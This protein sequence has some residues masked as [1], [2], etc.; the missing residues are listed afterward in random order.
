MSDPQA[1]YGY[2][3]WP[4]HPTS[5]WLLLAV[6]AAVGASAGCGGTKPP[7][8]EPGT[9]PAR[10]PRAAEQPKRETAKAQPVAV[11]AEQLTKEVMDGEDA[12][13][14][15]YKDR[16]LIVEGPFD[17]SYERAVAGSVARM[18]VLERYSAPGSSYAIIS[19]VPADQWGKVDGLTKGLGSNAAWCH[20]VLH[21]RLLAARA[22]RGTRIVVLDPRRTATADVADLHLPL[23]PGSDVILFN[24]RITTLDRQNPQA[25]AIAIRGDRFVAAGPCW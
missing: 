16:Q 20:P 18:M 13:N 23:A 10:G 24:G 7:T 5:T 17:H 9:E 4:F 19:K 22:A 11:T 15:K 25:Q 12:A 3:R 2:H 8:P 14:A 1:D 21:Q 6:S